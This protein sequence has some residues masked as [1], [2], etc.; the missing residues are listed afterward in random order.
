MRRRGLVAATLLAAGCASTPVVPTLDLTALAAADTRFLEGCYRC[1]VAARAE[2][3]RLAQ[4]SFRTALLP[5]LFETELLIALRER[6]LALDGEVE[7]TL[8]RARR[9][10]ADL[11]PAIEAGRYL[12]IV[13][14]IPADGLGW[15]RA[16]MREL[17]RANPAL[18]RGADDTIQ[19]LDGGLLRPAVRL[20]LALAIDCSYAAAPG[21]REARA[22]LRARVDQNAPPLV[23][24]RA[25]LCSGQGEAALDHVHGVVP[26]SAEAAYALGR[27]ALSQL[28]TGGGVRARDFVAEALVGFPT[29]PA[30][31]H[32]AGNY[33]RM[34]GDCAT[35][36]DRY[37]E[38]LAAKPRHEDVWLGRTICLTT[39]GRRDEAIAAATHMLDSEMDNPSEPLYWRAWNHRARGQ[40]DRA[41][42]DIDAARALRVAPDVLTLAGMIEHDQDDLE[43][44][45]RDLTRVRTMP[46]QEANCVAVWYLSSVQAKRSAWT[47]AAPGFEA[48][49][50][51]Y[52]RSAAA[53]E[54]ALGD[55]R[56]DTAL[57][58]AYRASR[59]A[60]LEQALADDRR[61]VHASAM[62]A[63]KFFAVAGDLSKATV[64]ADR[65]AADP[66]LADDLAAVREYIAN[67][68]P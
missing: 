57:D 56:D 39:V 46:G 62:N 45:L 61:Q 10:A 47:E 49:L 33:Y 18:A 40:L 53:N 26:E 55:I 16:E 42:A 12:Q 68:R 6:E 35:A 13:E 22:N 30:A 20:Y 21:R 67:R 17:V 9:L 41:R 48:A 52:E 7:G 37:T 27:L 43:P 29:S 8:Q 28:A 63:A 59:L 31:R 34:V 58:P 15:P 65:A 60:A 11:P 36:L 14:A 50:A 25:A 1:L 51:C 32:L 66:L 54:A 2:Y 44:A 3:Q 5:R 4:G 23:V 19:W 38:V 24:Y 64:L